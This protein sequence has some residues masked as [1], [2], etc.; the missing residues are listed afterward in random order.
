MA[1]AEQAYPTDVPPDLPIAR[2]R[3][4][5]ELHNLSVDQANASDIPF[6]AYGRQAVLVYLRYNRLQAKTDEH[7]YNLAKDTG[8][9][10]ISLEPTPAEMD[11]SNVSV[12]IPLEQSK[13]VNLQEIAARAD[14][15]SGE[16]LGRALRLRNHLAAIG[17]NGAFHFIDMDRAE[18]VGLFAQE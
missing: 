13:R 18:P 10:N 3:I 5:A 16:L 9:P 7:V 4:P 2:F 1:G 8:Y 11:G 14:K 12:T 17:I 15:T 6:G